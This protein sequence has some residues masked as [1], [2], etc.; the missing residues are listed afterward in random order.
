[1]TPGFGC[2]PTDINFSIINPINYTPVA[3]QTNGISYKWEFGNGQMSNLENPP[4][5]TFNSVSSY[6]VQ[7]T[8]IYDTIGFYIK[9]VK[10]TSVG[11][12]DAIGYG[13]P[14]I[15]IELIDGDNVTVYTT[16]PTPNDDN[17]P[18]IYS[19]NV[20]LNNPPY[21]IRIMDDDSDN[22]WGT[23]DDNCINGD[24]NSA[25]TDLLLPDVNQ[26]GTTTQS[27]TNQSLSF[28]YDIYKDTSHVVSFDTIHI[29][30]NPSTP[31]ITMDMNNPVSI[32]TPDL[33]YVY[34]W[35]QDNNPMYD[36]NNVIIYP[37]EQGDY[38]VVA[39]N[40]HGC[41]STSDPVSYTPVGLSELSKSSFKLYPNPTTGVVYI[42]TAETIK[43]SNLSIIDLTGRIL[44][45]QA[46]NGK[47]IFQID[48]SILSEGIYIVNIGKNDGT[49]STQRLVVTE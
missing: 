21:K 44:L 13:E 46:L 42:E 8:E 20:Q 49:V 23:A 14:D 10:I 29:Y 38:T 6:P 47:N 33:G 2:G 36:A 22:M 40:E 17:L 3:G 15:Y 39:V 48:A 18:Q 1:M 24:E 5:Q 30:A 9:E 7:L 32:S 12:D 26:Y 37:S 43:N 41:Y 35:N 4:T 27:A 31:V 34:Q 45:T 25:T 16:E 11:C 19:M 28:T